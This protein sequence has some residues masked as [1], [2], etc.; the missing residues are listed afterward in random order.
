MNEC[1]KEDKYYEGF[2]S[3]YMDV[4]FLPFVHRI[5]LQGVF[6]VLFVLLLIFLISIMRNTQLNKKVGYLSYVEEHSFL[7]ELKMFKISDRGKNYTKIFDEI[8]V[9]N[10]VSQRER[11][12]NEDVYD[13]LDFV[14]NTSTDSVFQEF[15]NYINTI[16]DNS[17]VLRY[18]VFF[19]KEVYIK[20]ITLSNP[21][22]ATLRIETLAFNQKGEIVEKII[23]DVF[24]TYESEFRLF[25]EQ[26]KNFNK[27]EIKFLVTDYLI[28]IVEYV[29]IE[30]EK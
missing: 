1:L 20:S 2:K 21:N 6:G 17:P 9:K 4:Y 8:V 5:I 10:Y 3:W 27:T 28:N 22:Q 14:Q 13:Q 7:H 19:V 16:N 30:N 29:N 18:S 15:Y 11:Y 23:W 26:G 25:E 24:L 12:Q